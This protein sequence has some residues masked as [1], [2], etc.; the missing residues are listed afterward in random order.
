M[1]KYEKEPKP[2]GEGTYAIVYRVRA[3]NPL[4][5]VCVLFSLLSC[6][7]SRLFLFLF[8]SCILLFA[9]SLHLSCVCFPFFHSRCVCFFF[10]IFVSCHFSL[11]VM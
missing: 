3:S 7:V 8:S 9:P 6:G 11:A 4:L 5:C 1:D 10:S 2:L